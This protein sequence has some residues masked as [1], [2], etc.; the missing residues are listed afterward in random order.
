[1][2]QGRN[3]ASAMAFDK[4]M[5]Q[6]LCDLEI[7]K[8]IKF[9]PNG[10][11]VLYSTSLAVGHRKGK[12]HVSTLWLASSSSPGSSRQLTS[13]LFDD[14][15]PTWH[16]DGNR[17]AF[18]SDRFNPGQS[19]AIWL[20]RLDGGDATAITPADN[21]EEI[22]T[23]AF[24]PSGETVAYI[25][26]D[27]KSEERKQKDDDDEPDPEVWGERWEYARLRLVDVKT[28]ETKALV[29]GDRHI[30]DFSWSAD[31]KK[32]VFESSKNP[33]IEE[34]MLTGTTISI[35]NVETGEVRDLCTMMN[36]LT[37]L[38][39]APDGKIYYIS[40][41]PE[42]KDSGG[43]AVYVVDPTD[44]SPK[45]VKIA[46]GEQ[47]DAEDLVVAGDKLLVNRAVRLSSV[48]SE[49]GGRDF[50]NKTDTEIWVWDIF[51][52]PSNESPTLAASLSSINS[53]YEVFI[54][55]EGHSDTKLSDHGRALEGQSFGSCTI[56][57]CQSSD[58]QVELDGL[59]LTPTAMVG[60]NGIP[61]EPIPTFVMIHGG[62]TTRNCAT[63]DAYFLH[64]SPFVL[65][66][67]YGVLLPQYRGSSGRGETFGS[68]SMG[69][70][71][72]YDYADIVSVTDNAVQK[73]FADGKRLMVGGWSQ[74]G[75]LTYLCSV[76][77]GLH[78]LGWRFNAAVAGAGV[79]DLESLVLTGDLGST[80][81]IELSGGLAAWNQSPDDTRARQGSAIWEVAGAVEE[82]RR[83]GEIVIP[84]MLIL[85][86]DM[87]DRCPFTQGQGFRRALRA[88]G[89]PCE[90]VAYPGEGHVPKP[91]RFWI[92]MLERI[93]RWC[94]TYIGPGPEK[95]QLALR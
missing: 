60:P 33:E 57:T 42:D 93:G 95:A 56:L 34:P 50:F 26:A 45:Y 21:A 25:S 75:L 65:S 39:W 47:D 23:F 2:A 71:G 27:E 81:E 69:G 19:S 62:P 74:G 70:Q 91:Q 41:T 48:I 15:T 29:G 32:I 89:L 77:N 61:K 63:F 9:S 14:T 67:G 52:D 92:D 88:H 76:R 1:M 38:T 84:P 87:D 73:G 5:A 3:N 24:S 36:E 20:L 80:Y 86:G 51:W 4:K 12:N 8:M 16:P 17:V 94:D 10:Q 82:S 53:T 37:N 43:K 54:V 44:A 49:V 11:N 6:T 40:G 31:G 85:H 30:T 28:K 59:Y 78:D 83:R 35:V 22:D 66:K 58:G 13:G 79:C 7:P 55:K 64:W 18:L 46:C 90:F 72:K 68:Y